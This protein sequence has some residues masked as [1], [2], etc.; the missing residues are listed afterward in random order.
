M[1]QNTGYFSSSIPLNTAKATTTPG[2][3]EAD[4]PLTRPTSLK[5]V[6]SGPALKTMLAGGAHSQ[7]KTPSKDDSE[8]RDYSHSEISRDVATIK[9]SV[10][11]HLTATF[12][13]TPASIDSAHAYLASAF[14][15]R[16]RLLQRWNL[17]NEYHDKIGAKRVYYMSLE[18]LIGRTFDNA[19]LALGLRQEYSKV[20]GDVGFCLEDIIDEERDAALGNGGLGRL[21]ACY[22]DSMACSN[23]PGW[24]YGLRYKYGMFQQQILNG[25]QVEA[26]DCWLDSPNPW[27][28]PR[29]DVTYP[30][31]FYGHLVRDPHSEHRFKWESNVVYDAMA[32]DVPVPGYGTTNVGNIRLWSCKT[33]TLFDLN[34]FNSGDYQGATGGQVAAQILTD[35]LYPN[36]NTNDGKELRLRQEYLFCSA[37]M[38]DI[39]ARFRKTNRPLSELPD[40]AAI[41]L[42]DT[43]P[44]LGVPELMRILIDDEGLSWD[45]AWDIT[46]RTFAFTNHTILPEAMEKWPVPMLDKILPRHMG[47]IYDINL[48]FLQKVEKQFPGDREL[49]N[50][51]SIIEESNPQQVRMAFLACVGSHKVN[52][53]AAIHSDIIKQTI[54][55]DFVRIQGEDKFI[56][57]TN[58][59]SPR[60]WMNE[61]NP[62][63]SDLITEVVGDRS[64]VNDLTKVKQLEG[65]LED[66]NFRERWWAAKQKNKE[67]LAE[68]ILTT[69]GIKVSA[70]AL[71]D[72]QVKRIHEYKRQLM[73]IFSV[74]YRYHLLKQMSPEQR[75]QEVPRVVIFAGKAAS[76]YWVAKQVIKL[77][78]SVAEVV[79]SDEEIGDVLKVVFIPDYSVTAAEVIIPAS[80][81]SQHISTAGT[82][83]SGTSNMKFVLNGG[84]ILGTVDGANIEIGEE[85]GEEQ[86]FFFGCL[87]HEVEDFRH[88]LR[89][90]QPKPDSALQTAFDMIQRNTFGDAQLFQ[91]LIDAI[92][93]GGDVY[94]LSVD[95]PSYIE[96][97]K[98][99]E[100]AYRNHDEW[101][102]KSILSVARMAKF[103]SDRSIQEYAEEV[104]NIEPQPVLNCGL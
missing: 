55:K 34:K 32:F 10:V 82:E 93:R 68:Y 31:K 60:R 54:F 1:S 89:F 85:I 96:A 102:T 53:V 88:Y 64:W 50:K 77:I 23:Y 72:I 78:N 30:V 104:W 28:F 35:V 17:T 4:V 21:A 74:I 11:M 83:A 18:F 103:S 33:N 71:F 47:I 80:D 63:M 37:T 95:F 38:Q 69:T 84:I 43:H 36:D 2:V 5:R 49:L 101:V 40:L 52:G 91:P 94:L 13:R 7:P 62:D 9:N 59:V 57:K 87:A 97:H 48:F 44:T 16:D 51:I 90:N 19:L 75:E 58:G 73:N 15:V 76:G 25:Y 6:L 22:V 26:P 61:C 3:H 100:E 46:T 39:L 56:N 79:N 12:L 70:H 27:E 98:A 42:N 65:K 24:G 41:Q 14:S 86:I 99:V 45:E 8:F 66:V 29:P 20:L 67:R 81:I 92:M